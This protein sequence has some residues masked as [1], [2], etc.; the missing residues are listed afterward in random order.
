MKTQDSSRPARSSAVWSFFD[1]WVG[2]TTAAIGLMASLGGGIGWFVN[3]HRQ[4]VQHDAA[5]RLAEQQSAGGDYAASLQT[6][7]A[8]LKADPLDRAALDDQ[9]NAA[10]LWT[11]N[12]SVSVPEGRTPTDAAAPA[13]DQIFSVL[14]SGLARSKGARAADIEAHLGWAHW[15]NQRIAAREFGSAAEQNFRGALA[16][17]PHNVYANAMLAGWMLQTGGSVS[18]AT[19]HFALALAAG[20]ARPFIRPLQIGGY[21]SS[22]QP[23]SRAELMRSVNDMR[24]NAEPLDGEWR[25]RVL[26][27]CCDPGFLGHAQLVEAL[28]A[29]SSDDAWST[30]LWLDADLPGA[31]DAADDALSRSF[32]QATLFE[33][34]GKPQ[35]SLAEFRGLQQQLAHRPGLLLDSVNAAIARL[36]RRA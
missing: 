6:S 7:G 22:G 1:T 12:F 8:L 4:S 23:G 27:F 10:M 36:A 18:E 19:Q 2:R 3:H 30:Y 17:D 33:I 13:L 21:L 11:E 25:R 15:L 5:L 29:V 20:K 14:D 24:R 26:A 31:S 32:I 28:S 35:Q 9:V 16:L 34:S